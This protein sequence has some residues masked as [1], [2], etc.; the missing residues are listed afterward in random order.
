MIRLSREQLESIREHG[1]KTYPHECCGFLVG[2]ADEE[3]KWITDLWPVENERE[4]QAQRR[5][6]LIAP[7]AVLESEKRARRES[8]EIVGVYHSHPDHPGEPSEFDREHAWPFYSYI[9]VE[10]RSGEPA[11]PLSWLLRED[12]TGFDSELIQIRE[13][14][15]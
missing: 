10:V 13:R 14:E 15:E 6:Y 8:K 11:T 5:R 12:R 3:S 1:R 2:R 7:E 9:I 4:G